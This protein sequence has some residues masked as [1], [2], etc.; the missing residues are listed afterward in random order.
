MIT[1]HGDSE[2]YDLVD[3]LKEKYGISVDRY[4]LVRGI[5]DTDLY[6]DDVFE[7][8]YISYDNYLEGAIE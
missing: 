7:T 6:Y 5:I 1:L 8:I 3:L 2:V 4:K